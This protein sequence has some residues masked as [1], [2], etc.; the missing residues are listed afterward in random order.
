MLWE[1]IFVGP[2][3]FLIEKYLLFN[4]MKQEICEKEKEIQSQI[5]TVYTKYQILVLGSVGGNS[6]TRPPQDAQVKNIST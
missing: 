4:H 6:Y 5:Y 1:I 2:K 3:C